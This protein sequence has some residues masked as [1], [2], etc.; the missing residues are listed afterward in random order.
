M[1]STCALVEVLF[2]TMLCV[3]VLLSCLSSGELVGEVVGV[4]IWLE[5][6]ALLIEVIVHPLF[7]ARRRTE[8]DP[9]DSSSFRDVGR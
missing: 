7:L 6:E 3:D 1:F 8:P 2:R 4:F 5:E 9:A